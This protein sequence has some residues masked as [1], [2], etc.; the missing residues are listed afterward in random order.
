MP[1]QS[2][3]LQL[4][5][6]SDIL[7]VWAYIAQARLDE[8]ERKHPGVVE[9]SYQFCSVFG[10]TRHKIGQGWASR[11][12]YEGFG[13]HILEVAEQYSHV[14]VHSKLWRNVR[15]LSSTP[16]HL[17]LK[18]VQRAAPDQTAP[19]INTL[20]DRFFGHCEDISL[21][22]VLEDTLISAQIDVGDIKR[23]LHNGQAHADLEADR[24]QQQAS[25]VSGSPT[26][27][28]NDGRQKLYGNVGYGVIEANITELL[29]SPVSGAASWC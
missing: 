7:C 6:F 5:C 25:L 9:T 26:I 12:G 24:R 15:P 18:A 2:E 16:A 23:I 21:W 19:L 11:G 29:R 4:T 20:R 14:S 8:A 10:D 22:T 3:R 17:V 27:L 13:A 28:L 1:E